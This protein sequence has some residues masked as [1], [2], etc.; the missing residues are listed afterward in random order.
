MG[1]GW[2]GRSAVNRRRYAP[3]HRIRT[4]RGQDTQLSGLIVCP[5]PLRELRVAS[6]VHTHCPH[7]RDELLQLLRQTVIRRAER[8]RQQIPVSV[9]ETQLRLTLSDPPTGADQIRVV[10]SSL[11][12]KKTAP[13]I[14]GAV[15]FIQIGLSLVREFFDLLHQRVEAG[16]AAEAFERLPSQNPIRQFLLR[17]PLHRRVIRPRYRAEQRG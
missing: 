8:V 13:E 1:R 16:I 17:I 10:I 15:S 11:R 14:V 3:K 7:E 5:S 6:A 12:S 2:R 9:L 4:G